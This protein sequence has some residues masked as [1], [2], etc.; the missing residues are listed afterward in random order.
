LNLLPEEA[1]DVLLAVQ[2]MREAWVSQCLAVGAQ[3]VRVR[4]AEALD[5][6]LLGLLLTLLGVLRAL[7]LSHAR[8]LCLVKDEACG[9]GKLVGHSVHAV[10]EL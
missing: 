6:L 7:L 3:G 4:A 5:A 10:V 1:G 9:T 8:A 2:G